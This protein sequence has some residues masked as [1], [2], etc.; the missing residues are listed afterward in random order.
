MRANPFGARGEDGRAELNLLAVGAGLG[1]L[2]FIAGVAVLQHLPIPEDNRDIQ[3]VVPGVTFTPLPAGPN[4]EPGP[5][6]STLP[7]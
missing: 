6:E 7:R 4:I 2:A 1:T 3:P 5:V